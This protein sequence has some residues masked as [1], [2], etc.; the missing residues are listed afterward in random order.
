MTTSSPTIAVNELDE[1][2][3]SGRCIGCGMC[4]IPLSFAE[5]TSKV[6]LVWSKDEEIWVPTIASS[7]AASLEQ[8]VC[9]GAKVD[10]KALSQDVF[11]EQ[12]K[13]GFVGVTKSIQ[14]GYAT[15]E[16]VRK[17]AASGGVTTVLLQS[18]L[19]EDIIDFAYCTAGLDPHNGKGQIARNSD[20]L[21]N[22]AGSHYHPVNFGAALDELAESNERFA[23]VGLP[24]EV[25]AMRSVMAY[26]DDIA[27]RCVAIIGLF[28]GGINRY[29]GIGHYLSNFGVEAENVEEID[30][31]DGVWPGQLA[32]KQKN[33]SQIQRIPRIRGNSRWN[34][35]RYMV[36]FQGYWML[37][38]CRICPDQISDFADIAVGDPHLTRFKEKES[39]GYSAVIAR[40]DTGEQLLQKAV[41]DGI[42]CSEKL[43][44]DELVASQGYTLENRRH[45]DVTR[46]M[47]RLLGIV[48]PELKLYD[49][50]KGARSWHQ[51]VY[52]FVDLYK[53]KIRKW[54]FLRPFYVPIQIG[55]YLFLT[56]SPRLIA[57]RT[58][59]LLK[60]K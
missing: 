13:D 59:K 23:F 25:S 8:R 44:R 27:Q 53:I 32:L 4:S 5:T 29:S 26:R 11:G 46:N 45:A 19:N 40:T 18:W 1:V 58:K 39:A 41:A 42:I 22:S 30:Y 52:A 21:R 20:D 10:M 12:P 38:R 7:D 33:S 14:A 49:D 28:C 16:T 34:I 31:R 35:L 15:D 37:P 57:S 9:P 55:E 47:A 51:H 48:A 60:N 54:T 2:V 17:F 6:D 50:V 24:C 36:S 3:S 56:F 43:S